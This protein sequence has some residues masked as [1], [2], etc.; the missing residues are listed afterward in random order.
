[1]QGASTTTSS[2]LQTLVLALVQ[3]PEVQ[4]K[5]HEEIDRVVGSE[6]APTIED[7]ENMPYIQA[8]IKEVMFSALH[9]GKRAC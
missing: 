9:N 3:F 2:Y 4:K 1:L 8:I 5:A 6:R 7:I